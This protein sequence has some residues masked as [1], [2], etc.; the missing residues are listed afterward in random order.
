MTGACAQ[1]LSVGGL[2]GLAHDLVSCSAIITSLVSGC[3]SGSYP[4]VNA[5]LRRSL[6]SGEKGAFPKRLPRMTSSKTEA[7]LFI[8]MNSETNIT[9]AV[10]PHRRQFVIGPE[11]FRFS[12]EWLCRQLS[13]RVWVSYCPELRAGWT[14]DAERVSWGLLGLAVQT[15]EDEADP[16]ESISGAATDVVPDLYASWAGRWVLIGQGQ[17]HMDA[18]GLLG[19]F[20][21]RGPGD[22]TWV[23]SSPALL[24]R[25]L[26]PAAPLAADP[27]QLRYVVGLSWFTPPRSRFVGMSRLLPS[28]IIE[29]DTG[30]IL[31]RPLMPPLDP[32]R[33]F[34]ETLR[35]LQQC[36]ITA[37]RRLPAA[38][39]GLWLGLTG[40]YDSRLMLAI[41]RCAGINVRPFTR[42][43]GRM[44]VA[45]RLLPPKLAQQLGFEHVFV[46]G[47]GRGHVRKNLVAEHCA[48]HVSDGDAE[49]FLSGVRES[50]DGI[51]F[52]G[53][54]FA[55]ASGFW[56]LRLLPDCCDNPEVGSRQLARL[57][58]EPLNS[59]A[60][61]GV[62]EWLE[63]VL[64]TPHAHLD[65]R[66]RF[67]M[68][69][70]LAGWL[71]SKEQM[72]D[73]GGFER[74]PI[75]NAAR[76]YALLLSLK[77][78]QRLGSGV[79][80][81]LIRR[82]APELLRY[83]FNPPDWH[84]GVGRALAIR[85]RQDPLYMLRKLDNKLRWMW[86]SFSA[87]R[88]LST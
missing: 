82:I 68:E 8:G 13:P 78:H 7:L 29:L 80:V 10:K 77:E 85:T 55:V 75:L 42:V 65:W 16:L 9:A 87:R 76:T 19:C 49:P 83:P 39:S 46:R 50:L 30:R 22:R 66:D 41:A 84:F 20:F 23:S 45:D 35:L 31:P 24:S 40:G 64:Q 14:T 86:R 73:L 36:F 81:E 52:G 88:T 70:R 56:K 71:S 18:C 1:P 62:R 4:A 12:D 72:Y 48:G 61:A 69:Q 63:W 59:T 32:S 37:L 44:S 26:S 43:A 74:F 54:C 51:A 15:L 6:F 25:I 67:F 34:D 2:A 21:G 11:P 17:V 27:R 5:R 38:G 79:Q 58:G 57:L 47:R 3:S 28:Q 53:H 60:T 33:E